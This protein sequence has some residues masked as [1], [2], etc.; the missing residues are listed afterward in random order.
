MFKNIAHALFGVSKDIVHDLR[1][2]LLVVLLMHFTA[3]DKDYPSH[4]VI[5]KVKA[6]AQLFDV[7]CD[8]LKGWCIKINDAF[9]RLNGIYL[10]P[11][12][13]TDDGAINAASV[14]DMFR[15]LCQ[16]IESLQAG[17]FDTI[18]EIKLLHRQNNELVQINKDLLESNNFLCQKVDNVLTLLTSA[19]QVNAS[20][21][22]ISS[23]GNTAS[24]AVQFFSGST[25]NDSK[26]SKSS[27][28]KQAALTQYVNGVVTN[29]SPR[30]A[31]GANTATYAEWFE[32]RLQNTEV[33]NFFYCWYVHQLHS[34]K[35][36]AD[37]EA[38]RT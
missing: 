24:A 20:H 26:K 22:D 1:F 38:R 6:T 19:P 37:T 36:A 8:K 12:L 7:D 35:T 32:N 11:N 28:Q 18:K 31:V 2:A 27:G 3:M 5:E 17:S 10:L 13:L 33:S 34:Y 29:A 30:A 23:T 15:K 14:Q 16:R 9:V 4:I 25:R 21:S